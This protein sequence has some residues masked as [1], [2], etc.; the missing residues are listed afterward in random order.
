MIRWHILEVGPTV[1]DFNA[2]CCTSG[3]IR[4]AP[5]CGPPT[6]WGCMKNSREMINKRAHSGTQ[7]HNSHLWDLISTIS[8]QSLH[9][10]TADDNQELHPRATEVLYNDFYAYLLSGPSTL[11]EVMH[12]Q[13]DISALLSF[14]GFTLRKW[15]SNHPTFLDTFPE[16]LQDIHCYSI[17]G[18]GWSLLV[19]CGILILT[20]LRFRAPSLTHVHHVSQQL[21]K[22]KVLSIVAWNFDPLGPQSPPIIC[23]KLFLQLLC[24]DKLECYERLTT[25]LQRSW[26]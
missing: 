4:I 16:E 24:Q 3:R 14:S 13:Q 23:F 19:C 18:M 20:N 22:C 11:E 6:G 9:E 25:H 10:E 15:A 21:T 5:F 12:L 7:T 1:Q 8:G 26:N 2:L 17:I